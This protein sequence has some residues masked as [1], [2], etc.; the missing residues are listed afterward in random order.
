M[1]AG[2]PLGQCRIARARPAP[3]GQRRPGQRRP[4][5]GGPTRC[6]PR[7]AATRPCDERGPMAMSLL[8]N[9]A[10]GGA[11]P[12][13]ENEQTAGEQTAG[14]QTTTRTERDE[15]APS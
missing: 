5:A 13:D 10:P 9:F 3:P 8:R 12:D 6:G 7:R 14:E 11:D 2:R 4:A 15:T 1:A